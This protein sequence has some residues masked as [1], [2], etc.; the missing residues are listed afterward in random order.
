MSVESTDL[1]IVGGGPAGLSAAREAA[2]G[3]LQVIVL[4]RE[5]EVGGTPR[6][7]GHL[8]FG[9]LDYGRLWTGPKY[10]QR[11]CAS[12][13]DIDLRCGHAATAL[14]AGGVVDISG[15]NGP[16][17]IQ[18]RR[19]LIATGVY[20]KP[21]AARLI[22]GTRP[23]GILTTGA[24]QRFVYLHKQLPCR[25]PIVV[26]SELIAYSTIL[27]LRQFGVKPVAFVTSARRSRARLA[28]AAARFIFDIPTLTTTR[29]LAIQGDTKVSSVLIESATGA[30]MLTCDG[31]VFSGDWIPESM[32]LRSSHIGVDSVTQKPV[33]DSCYRTADPQVFA[34]GNV[35]G[36]VRSSGKCALEGRK[37]AR[38][39]LADFQGR[40]P[41]TKRNQVDE[42]MNVWRLR[43]GGESEKLCFDSSRVYGHSSVT[44]H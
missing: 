11:L 28:Q 31:I 14:S 36:L 39:I 22:S 10:A 7:C 23:F 29:I 1:V 15:S 37:A 16:Y 6:Y 12:V 33:V 35:L 8:G 25:L 9:M 21:C 24:L 38:A 44:T 26:G 5:A 30:R 17:T 2:N 20:E 32:L 43:S 27:T 19:V 42:K 3:G 13:G 18:A 4:E 40:L 41:L 34:A